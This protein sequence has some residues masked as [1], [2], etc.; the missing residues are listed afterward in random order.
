MVSFLTDLLGSS[1][2][3]K[4][5]PR[6]L[7]ERSHL[8]LE[9]PQ[10]DA[11]FLR[12]FIPILESPS[13]QEKGQANL[14][15]Y[16]LVGRAGE[17]FSYGGAK[18]RRFNLTFNI[19]LLH[20]MEMN[21][22]EGIADRFK[23]GFKLFFEDRKQ[24]EKLFNLRRSVAEIDEEMEQLAAANDGVILEEDR[25]FYQDEQAYYND[26]LSAQE[27]LLN[28]PGSTPSDKGIDYAA[29][30]RAYYN[31]VLQKIT[32]SPPDD[33]FNSFVTNILQDLEYPFEQ[34]EKELND[35]INLVYV[36]V[37]LIRAS[38]LNNSNNTS[39]GP[40]IVR[41]THGAMYNNVPC[42]VQDY[43]IDVDEEVGYEVT[44]VTPKRLR[45]SLTLVE[46]RTG[47]FGEYIPGTIQDGDNLT[48]WESI[49]ENN[50]YDPFNGVISIPSQNSK[51]NVTVGGQ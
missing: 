28:A 3:K 27:D 22:T 32:G 7:H 45:I 42:L 6:L 37:N 24:Q 4:V 35:V 11:R 19:S 8:T 29:I 36:W 47:S 14:N 44:T 5:K 48:G 9:F 43:S 50:V 17:L 46:S 16:S 30:H 13:I 41:L 18:S 26:Q 49:I 21:T 10:P 51:G 1:S 40:P 38:V 39:F 15:A 33:N 12:T 2:Y 25:Q 20:V 34:N 31:T 23:R